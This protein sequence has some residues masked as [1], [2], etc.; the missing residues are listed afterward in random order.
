MSDFE[1]SDGIDLEEDLDDAYLGRL[2][3]LGHKRTFERNEHIYFQGDG[4]TSVY[5]LREGLVKATCADENGHETLLKIHGP[6]SLIGLSALRPVAV[7]DANGIALEPAVTACIS[8]DE[9]FNYM[10]SDGE[11]GVLLVR[12]LLKR[13]QQL[14]SRVSDVTGHSVEQRLARILLQLHAE[15][16]TRTPDG[17]VPVL[18]VTHEDLATLVLSRRQYV[19]A[20]LRTFASHGLIENRRRRIRINAPEKLR[21]IFSGQYTFGK[22]G[23]AV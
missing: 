17:E 8:R 20:I 4:A 1:F 13:Q 21:Q 18:P 2:G 7:R 22:R 14:H 23:R 9:F 3:T 12:V 16:A 10:R 19:T 15:A 6:G 5:V 11:L